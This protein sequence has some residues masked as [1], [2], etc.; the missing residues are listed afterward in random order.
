MH[1]EDNDGGGEVNVDMDLLS[2]RGSARASMRNLE[3]SDG[4]GGGNISGLQFNHT[5]G[6]DRRVD[7][8]S[9][10]PNMPIDFEGSQSFY[11]RNPYGSSNP[12]HIDAT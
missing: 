5:I 10:R 4:E 11:L 6:N 2:Y 9:N 12:N 1:Y 7:L 3:D 8:S